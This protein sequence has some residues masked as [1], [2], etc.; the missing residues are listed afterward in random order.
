MKTIIGLLLCLAGI[1]VGV[2]VGAY[3]MFIRG[4]IQV[5]TSI[6]P[7]INAVG[8]AWGIARVVSAGITGWFSFFVLFI[9]GL[10]CLN[11]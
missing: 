4:I 11:S 9:P 1:V 3:L 8:I 6:T 10:A 5:V 7:T 2:Y